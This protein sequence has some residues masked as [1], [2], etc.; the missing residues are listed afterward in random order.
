MRLTAIDRAGDGER[1]EERRPPDARDHV[2]VL[3]ADGQAPVGRWRLDADA[4]ER[5]RRDGE[6]RV[7]EP[8]GHLDDGRPEDVREDL[9][10]QD[11]QARIS[12]RSLAAVT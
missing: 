11:E 8:D 4:E 2:V 12:P 3:L 5:Q 1:R 10:R 7:P 6:D 9:A